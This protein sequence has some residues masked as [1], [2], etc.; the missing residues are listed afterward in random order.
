MDSGILA[1]MYNASLLIVLAMVYELGYSLPRDLKRFEKIGSGLLIGLLGIAIMYLP[2]RLAP[3]IHID[4]R[5]ILLGISG[6]FM[7]PLPMIIAG[8]VTTAFRIYQSGAGTITGVIIIWTSGGLGVLWRMKYGSRKLGVRGFYLFGLLLHIAMIASFTTLPAPHALEVTRAIAIPVLIVY[9]VATTILG[10][11]MAQRRERNQLLERLRASEERYANLFDN[12]HTMLLVVDPDD[13]SILEANPAAQAFY[14]WSAEEFRRMTTYEIHTMPREKVAAEMARAKSEER[15]YFIFQHRRADGTTVDVEVHSSPVPWNEKPALVSVV[16]DITRRKTYEGKLRESEHRFRT[17]VEGAPDAIFVQAGGRFAFVN[18]KALDLFGAESPEQLLDTQVIDRMH[19]DYR[20]AGAERMRMLNE[21][22][23]PAS[24]LE[25][26]YLRLDGTPVDVDVSAVPVN[27]EGQRGAVVFVRDVSERKE[28]ERAQAEVEAQMIQQQK[29]ESIGTLAGGVAHE[30]NNPI[31]GIINYAQ[32]ILDERGMEDPAAGY[33]RE[34]MAESERVADITTNLLQFARPG[35]QVQSP[36]RVADIVSR[37]LSLINTVVKRD[38][39]DLRVDVPEDLPRVRCRSQ[40]IQ[41][42]IL[43]LL[44]NGRDALNERYPGYDPNKVISIA[45][46]L[47]QKEE[48]DWVRIS[49]EDRGMGIPAEARDRLFEPFFTTKE[50]GRGTGLG[51]AIS[52]GIIRDHGGEL[53]FETRPGVGTVF[54]VDLP[55]TPSDDDD[56]EDDDRGMT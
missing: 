26:V 5:S 27:H 44:T 16:H 7:G 20:E 39:I 12:T 50:R 48:R 22:I 55:I 21:E 10:L 30:I 3:G 41:Q 51:L 4:T 54:T 23:L 6:L 46:G 35:Y 11:L 18:E 43:N 45:A 32:L 29:M 14:G 36:A 33:A 15:N 47:V 19:P 49:V 1:L 38:Q 31:N 37:T 34:I 52:Y 8:I 40:Q 25:Q 17:L 53:A 13:G 42:V 2:F 56:E 28:L 24:S 9:P